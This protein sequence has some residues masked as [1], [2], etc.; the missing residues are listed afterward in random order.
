[1][2]G[3]LQDI[4]QILYSNWKLPNSFTADENH[5]LAKQQNFTRASDDFSMNI[6]CQYIL[7]CCRLS[8]I[9]LYLM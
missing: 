1:M 6:M 2:P 9:Q 5:D 4:H 7:F 8:Y 3:H